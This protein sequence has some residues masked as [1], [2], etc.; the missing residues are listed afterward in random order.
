MLFLP[1]FFSGDYIAQ[2]IACQV[3]DQQV[4]DPGLIPEL[5]CVFVILRKALYA[6]FSLVP[7]SIFPLFWLSL[8]LQT[9]PTC[10][11]LTLVWLLVRQS[12]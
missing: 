6:Y 10:E 11:C 4:A 7:S 1:R 2:L 9:E 3:S 12:G 5:Q 8:N